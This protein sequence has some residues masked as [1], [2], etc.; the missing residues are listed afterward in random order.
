MLKLSFRL[1]QYLLTVALLFCAMPAMAQSATGEHRPA[2]EKVRLQLKWFNQFQFAGYF[3]AIEKGYYAAEGLEV[4]IKERVLEKN[5]VKQV[6]AGESEYGVGDSGLLSQYAKGEPIVALAAIFQHNPLVFMARQD[7][8]IISP[9]E[10]IGKRVMSDIVSTNEAPLRAMLAGTGITEKDYKLMPQSNNYDLLI[11]REVDVI[12]GYLTD[13]PFYFKQ[14]GVKVNIINPQNYGIDF[15]GDIL[16]T[17]QRELQDHPGRAERFRRASLKGW[18]YALDHPD[19][20]IRII[21]GKYRSKLTIENLKFEAAETR[22]LILP[23]VI[24]IGQI[25]AKRMK[26]VADVYAGSGFN[27]PLSDAEL[28]GFIFSERASGLN[29]TEDEKA[30]LAAHP[31]I[32]VGIDRDFAPYEWIDEDGNYVGMAADYMAVLEKKLGV[33]FQIIKDKPWADILG[34]AERGELDMLSCAV[35]TPERSRYLTFTEPYKSTQA[36]IIDNGQGGFVGSLD[37]LHGKRV[38]VEKGYFM[39]ELLQKHHPQIELL[40]AP[41]THEALKLVVDGKADAYVGDAGSANYVIK[42]DSLLS[43]RFSGQTDYQSRHSVAITKSNPALASMIAKAMAS[44]SKEEADTIFNRWLGLKIEQG[45]RTET[46]VSYAAGLLLLF[47]LF[48]YWVYR[49]RKEISFRIAAETYEQSRSEI[50][51]LL[52]VGALLPDVLKAIVKSVELSSPGALCSI[53]LLDAEGRHLLHGAAPSLPDS[54]NKAIHGLEI[55]N[56]VGSCGTAAF[57]GKRVIAEDIQT[58]PYWAHYKELAGKAGL[59]SCWSEPIK[60]AEGKVLGSFAV[61]HREASIPSAKDIEV[62]QQAGNLAGIAIERNKADEALRS[63]QQ[64]LQELLQNSPIAVRIAAK[65]GH[66]VLFSNQRYAELINNTPE[67]TVGID[68]AGYYAHPQD[69]EDILQQLAQDNIISNRLIELAIP[70]KGTVWTMATYM[71][72]HFQGEPAVLGWFYDVTALTDARQQAELM[73]KSKSE[74]LANMS[75]E[76]RT[77]M[78]GI[79][80]LSQ[81]ALNQPTN[82]E[83]RDY[84]QKIAASSQSLLGILNDILD[85]SKLDAGHMSIENNP[86]DLDIVLDNLRN[87]FEERA[88]EKYLD[89][90]ITIDEK[91][92]RDLIG[93]AL[94]IQ[95]ILSNLLGNAIKF[96]AQGHVR[97]LI[98]TKQIEGAQTRL[99]FTVED[100]GIGIAAEDLDKLFHPFSQVDGSITRRFGGT[101]LGLAIS[102][103]LLELMGGSFDVMSQPGKGS[104]FSFELLLGVGSYGTI[105][106]T[107]QRTRH[108]AGNLSAKLVTLGNMLKGARILV[109]EDN[110]INQQVVQ[111]F[112]TLSGMEVRIANHGQEA[113]DL[114]QQQD[115]DAVLMDVHMPLMGGVEATQKIRAQEKFSTLPIIAITAGVTQEERNNCQASGM[116]DFIAKPVNPE[117]LLTTLNRWIRPGQP[118]APQS[119]P[120][121]NEPG[122]NTLTLPGFDFANL[123]K[124]LGN[125]QALMTELLVDFSREMAGIPKEIRIKLETGDTASARDLAHKIKGAAGNLGATELHATASRLE[126]GLKLG[127][128]DMPAMHEFEEAFERSMQAIASL[129]SQ[130]TKTPTRSGNHVALVMAAQKLERQ[131]EDHDFIHP[132]SL[133]EIQAHLPDDKLDLFERLQRHIKNIRYAEARQVLQ[134]IMEETSEGKS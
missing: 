122:T 92:P 117:T 81:L 56:G 51:E 115:F 130:M 13:Q 93:D 23:D 75:H 49:L 55:G 74:F 88:H 57:T 35:N 123:T 72:M 19:E 62:I 127:H 12:S 10:M 94:R 119:L 86:F 6:T 32:R 15:Y 14:K 17:S 26:A 50:L 41:D 87:L 89:F 18:K 48:G 134:Q 83:V 54:Y 101:G 5:F 109:A 59:G 63:S 120:M 116:N 3:A 22:K 29:L 95:Q 129:R 98:E 34:M 43:L 46:M 73:A 96:T 45:I 28:A 121:V 79:I 78:N 132:Q 36:I 106:E 128:V 76:I 65:G 102:H 103:N 37:H 33:R 108:D 67:N 66:R 9:Y 131:L 58:H 30:W 82:P 111:E 126:A 42:K 40:L 69:Y 44:I 124:M 53:L 110:A 64:S 85:F 112:L 1:L 118:S 52:A 125:N 91:T 7:S 60:N 8:G 104:R 71:K 4:E 105:R 90:N 68:P 39:Q 11:S 25:E 38:T 99:R 97:L 107:R 84:L 70:G 113:L 24:P 100:S 77:P 61:Y 114:L 80:G 47:L 16:F 2:P 31:V 20:L 21:H 27:R 133:N